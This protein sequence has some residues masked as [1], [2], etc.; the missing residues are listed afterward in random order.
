MEL[1]VESKLLGSGYFHEV[2]KVMQRRQ[3]EK[4]YDEIKGIYLQKEIMLDTPKEWVIKKV[5]DYAEIKEVP[6]DIAK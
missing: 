2:F 4:Q 6:K 5:K 1:Y 3:F